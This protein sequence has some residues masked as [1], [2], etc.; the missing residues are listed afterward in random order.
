[1]DGRTGTFVHVVDERWSSNQRVRPES[2]FAR[3][4]LRSA[5][6]EVL[7]R[8]FS[9][10][11][12]SAQRVTESVK[13]KGRKRRSTRHYLLRLEDAMAFPLFG[14]EQASPVPVFERRPRCRPF[15]GTSIIRDVAGCGLLR[16]IASKRQSAMGSQPYWTRPNPDTRTKM[17]NH[18]ISDAEP[19]PVLQSIQVS[20]QVPIQVTSRYPTQ[21]SST[22]QRPSFRAGSSGPLRSISSSSHDNSD[23]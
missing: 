18:S 23:S 19:G 8:A 3:E 12:D 9:M 13:L 1:M 10:R 20:I 22:H 16:R 2:V 15:E 6:S 5:V 11:R 7:G 17:Y 14:T 4:A 21:R